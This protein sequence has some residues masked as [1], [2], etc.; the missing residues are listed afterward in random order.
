MLS[1]ALLEILREYWRRFR[2]KEWLFPGRNPEKP[3]SPLVIDLVCRTARRKCDIAKPVTPH[4]LRHAFAVHLLESGADLRTIQLLLGH[5]NSSTSARY[6][7]LATS[8]VCATPSPLD[9]LKS[10]AP[11]HAEL[12]SVANLEPSDGPKWPTSSTATAKPIAKPTTLR[13]P[14]RS[15]APWAQS[16]CAAPRRW[17]AISSGVTTASM[18]GSPT[19]PVAIGIAQNAS[20]FPAPNGGGATIR[21][22]GDAV[23]PRGLQASRRGRRHCL[24]EQSDSLRHP[25]PGRRAGAERHRRRSFPSG[26]RDR[27]RMCAAHVG[28]ESAPSPALALLGSR[29]RHLARRR[30]MDGLPAWFLPSRHGS[31]APVSWLV[32]ALS[33]SRVHRRATPFLL[34][35]STPCGTVRVPQPSRSCWDAEWVVYAKPPFAGPRQVLTSIG[36]YTHR[37]AISNN[38][39][40][41]AD[42][43]KVSFR[44]KDYRRG[45]RHGVM[46]LAGFNSGRK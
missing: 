14:Q 43:R 21:A 24:P 12:A 3:I 36:G 23:L 9:S 39:L 1:P 17:A 29:W 30:S 13:C 33:R 46:T 10:V 28:P 32:P 34:Y 35:A 6:L 4:S 27:L 5:R 45:N 37:I 19:I 16:N 40:V 7:R 20:L 44:W 2:P 25:V 41:A 31:V 15:D 8:K 11:S 26:R 18:S 38:R 22:S 42:D